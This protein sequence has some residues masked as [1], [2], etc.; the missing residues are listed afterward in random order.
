MTTT[1]NPVNETYFK[2]YN[3]VMTDGRRAYI[4]ENG[5]FKTA[6]DEVASATHQKVPL[7]WQQ[8][9]FPAAQ[10]FDR[11][12]DAAKL[13]VDC[14]TAESNVR[15]TPELTLPD[16]TSFTP[17]GLRSLMLFAGIPVKMQ[18]WLAIYQYLPDLAR[19][20]NESLD[21][22]ELE[23]AEKGKAPRD[24]M[25]R[26]R[27]DA[28]GK[29][30]VRAVLSSQYAR[31]DNHT[32]CQVIANAL[33]G[34]E[35]VLVA[36]AWTN[37][38]ALSMDLLLPDELK[39]DPTN[40]WGVGF[41]F[42]N[43]EIGMGS[44]K[45]EPYV[46][47]TLTRTG[48]RWGGFSTIVSVDQRHSG[49]LD[50]SK[51]DVAVKRALGVALTEGRCMLDLLSMAQT[52]RINDASVVLAGLMKEAGLTRTDIEQAARHYLR[53]QRDPR[54]NDTAFGIVESIAL[55]AEGSHGDRR[56]ALECA[57]GRLVAPKLNSSLA[58]M[59]KH[60]D[61]IEVTAG[62]KGDKDLIQ[63]VR[64]ILGGIK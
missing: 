42:S 40:Q 4:D 50:V 61:D 52:I 1:Q 51:L 31:F 43:S 56:M 57:A 33:G 41:S 39:D 14:R 62:R 19:F 36:H 49:A 17:S 24:F 2:P 9:C 5:T 45:L 48:Y 29:L 53:G 64:D 8:R 28:A 38:D 21:R 34:L 47:R 59:A 37:Q 6:L 26:M 20:G 63:D 55:A 12:Y 18:E 3:F 32:A 35:D 13:N 25:V 30:E 46:F 44:F 11:V 16:G 15:L 7:T 22:R 27:K 58:D 23:W 54:T 60:W 10:L